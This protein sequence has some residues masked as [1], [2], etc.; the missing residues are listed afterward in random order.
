MSSQELSL[1]C[2]GSFADDVNRPGR[3]GLP[4]D[5]T[6]ASEEPEDEDSESKSDLQPSIYFF[7]CF[8]L[9][10]CKTA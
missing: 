8:W 5:P 9:M 4:S 3:K 6:I 1:H 7:F 10:L 2:Y